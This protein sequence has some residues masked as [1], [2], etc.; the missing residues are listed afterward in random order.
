MRAV[1][2]ELKKLSMAELLQTSPA[3]GGT[4]LRGNQQPGTFEYMF[5]TLAEQARCG[6]D[7]TFL[8]DFSYI[9][10]YELKTAPPRF[11]PPEC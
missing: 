10:L 4:V 11:T 8:L 1:L 6:W 3:L 5:S 7:V 2:R 9:N